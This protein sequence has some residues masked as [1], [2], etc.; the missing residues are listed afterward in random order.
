MRARSLRR[1]RHP[2]GGRAAVAGAVVGD[3]EPVF[4]VRA[5]DAAAASVIE[6][7]GRVAVTHYGAHPSVLRAAKAWSARVRAWQR[8][9][10]VHVETSPHR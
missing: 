6:H 2:L 3:D 10:E 7:W 9:H 1:R 4:I 8:A 5:T